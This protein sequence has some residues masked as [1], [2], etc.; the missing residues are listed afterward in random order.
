MPEVLRVGLKASAWRMSTS[1]RDL[2]RFS[3]TANQHHRILWRKII[4]HTKKSHRA[5]ALDLIGMGGQREA[6]KLDYTFA[7]HA[8]YVDG[9]LKA[10]KLG[11]I[12]LV[13]HDWGSAL[14]LRYA[15]LNPTNVRSIA[16]MES[17]LPPGLPSPGY[18]AMGDFTG[19]MFKALR[20]PGL[21]ENLVYQH[22]IFVESV[23]G[24]FG[25]GRVLQEAEMKAYR[26]PFPPPIINTS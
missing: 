8:R 26:R 4:P 25:S 10:M 2:L 7:Q 21:D 3:Y 6:R 24:R 23:L 17:L 9:F 15:C 14:G 18:D 1:A 11:D 5:I 19:T 22:N 20:T 13:V 16:L 12:T